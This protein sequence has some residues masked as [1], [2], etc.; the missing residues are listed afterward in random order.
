MHAIR[1]LWH[2]NSL[3]I[4]LLT[5]FFITLIGMSITGWRDANN[6]RA[7]HQQSPETYGAYVVSGDFIEGV[8]ENWESEFLQM[9]ALVVLTIFLRQKGADESKPL[10]GKMPQDIKSR[11]RV[12]HSQDWR[13]FSRAVR[14]ELYAHSL[15]I[16][17]IS[18]FFVSFF[19]HAI[20]GAQVYNEEAQYYGEPQISTIEYVGT[21]R[22]WYESL[23]N[24][25][26]EFLAVGTLMLLSIKLRERGS[27]E[28]KP[29]GRHYDHETG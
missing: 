13:T 1:K 17:L 28:S 23:Q 4:V 16:A 6:Q 22:F 5:I 12:I 14:H 20:G 7:D 26:S 2:D 24:W 10:R 11:Y 19:L 25:Q 21:S 9:W 29:V 3:S 15:S 27:P 8:F 18:I